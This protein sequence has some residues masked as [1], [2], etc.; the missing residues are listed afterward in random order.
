MSRIL[1][2]CVDNW[3]SAVN[4]QDGGADRIELCSALSEDGLTPSLGFAKL[5]V[6]VLSIPIFA[7]IRPRSGDFH[8]SKEELHIMIEDIQQM[9]AIGVHG[10]VVGIL[11]KD[12]QIDE[13]AMR[14]MINAAKP[15][16]V[17]FHRAFDYTPDPYDALNTL[18]NLQ[19][20]R[21]LTSGQEPKAIE[22]VDLLSELITQSSGR[23]IIMPGS[24]VKSANIRKL[25]NTGAN[26]Y[27]G[28]ARASGSPTTNVEEV[29][30]I[31]SILSK[32]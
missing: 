21:V 22:G 4:A 20:E 15:L 13:I 6:E 26:E 3:Q 19:I 28:S 14:R 11:Q 12:K 5:C 32:V 29:R 23:I 17:T 25:M 18:M 7:M 24:G 30:K 2:I 31:K 9:K 1:E 8:Y 27:H 16:P 10:I